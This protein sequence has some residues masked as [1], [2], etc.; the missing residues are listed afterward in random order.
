[1]QTPMPMGQ[2]MQ[3]MPEQF[4]APV[5]WLGGVAVVTTIV[6]PRARELPDVKDAIV[7]FEAFEQRFAKQARVS[8]FLAGLSGAYMLIKL[9]AWDRFQY[10]SLYGARQSEVINHDV[11]GSP[12]PGR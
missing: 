10:A 12:S 4:L 8:I 9:D 11:S 3:G 5:H 2:M 6:L 7:A 1:M